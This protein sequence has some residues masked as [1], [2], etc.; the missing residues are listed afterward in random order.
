MAV[1]P[2]LLIRGAILQI[3]RDTLARCV[4]VTL[5]GELEKTER[6][7][8]THAT[9]LRCLSGDRDFKKPLMVRKQKAKTTTHVWGMGADDMN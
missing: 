7:E 2:N 3:L 8:R 6:A 4:T 1:A 5:V 9:L